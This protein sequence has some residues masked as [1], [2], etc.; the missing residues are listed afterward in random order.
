M[1]IFFWLLLNLCA[2]IAGPPF[3]LALAAFAYGY[4]AAWHLIVDSIKDGQ[5]LWTAMAL[6]ASAIYEAIVAL[7]RRGAAPA[8]EL[9]I[10]AFSLLAFACSVVVMSATTSAHNAEEIR[11]KGPRRTQRMDVPPPGRVIG[12]SI[13]LLSIVATGFMTLHLYL[14]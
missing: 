2:P 7:E 4:R 8:L 9:A 13:A 11:Q 3:T 5:L 14:N 1:D 10:T 12:I 6:A